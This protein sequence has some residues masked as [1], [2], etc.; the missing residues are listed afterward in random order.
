M[1]VACTG[2]QFSIKSALYYV[3]VYDQLTKLTN[4]S[5]LPFPDL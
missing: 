3:L 1:K 4:L 2:R 5:E